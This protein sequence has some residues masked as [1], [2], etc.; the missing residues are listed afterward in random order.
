MASLGRKIVTPVETAGR[1]FP[2]EEYHQDYYQKNPLRY[3]FYRWN[4][5]RNQ[6]VK[7]VWGDKAYTGISGKH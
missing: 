2:A 5:G 1:F 3:R 4:C 7:E 6:R